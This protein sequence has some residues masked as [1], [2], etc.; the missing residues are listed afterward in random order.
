VTAGP[1]IGAQAFAV[2]GRDLRREW[3]RGEV[4]WVTIPFGAVALL[5]IPL[6]VGVD[7]AML[8][9]IGPGLFWVVVLL[10]GVLVTVRR[11]ADVSATTGIRL[12]IDP[13]ASFLGAAA[14]NAVLLL[15]FEVVV[16]VVAVLLYDLDTSEW[17]WLL[18]VVPGVAVGLG[19]L[20]TLAA[21]VSAGVGS[22]SLV[23]FL[24]APLAVPLLIGAT[25]A[26]GLEGGGGILPWVLMVLLV[27]VV[28]LVLGVVTARPL[29]ET[30]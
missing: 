24:V 8:R 28:A 13:A 17:P 1:G 4:A 20:G 7:A 26:A 23:P 3:R 29:Q 6:A 27:D 16:G 19:L 21:A 30:G 18:A 5:L 12:G 9:A 25:Q 2:A 10:F 22:P 11:T 15:V 14:A